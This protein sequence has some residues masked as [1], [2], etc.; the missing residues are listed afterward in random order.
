M[1]YQEFQKE[2]DLLKEYLKL[3]RKDK[4]GTLAEKDQKRFNELRTTYPKIAG[5]IDNNL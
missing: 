1:N 2:K 5:Y 4:N 3:A